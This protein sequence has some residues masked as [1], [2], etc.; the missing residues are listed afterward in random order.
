MESHGSLDVAWAPGDIFPVIN[1][2]RN[3]NV[4][5]LGGDVIRR[6]ENLIDYCGDNWYFESSQATEK[7]DEQVDAAA[8]KAESY[9]RNYVAKNGPSF[10]FSLVVE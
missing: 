2:L 7:L 6:R 5:I 3:Q 1:W 4:L 8:D 9:I 10:L